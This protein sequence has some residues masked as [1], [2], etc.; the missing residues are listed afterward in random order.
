MSLP[1]LVKHVYNNA[2]DDIIK[3]GKKIQA[4]GNTELV[5]IDELTSS[6]VFR[7]KDDTYNS[8]FKVHIQHFSN[9]QHFKLK[10]TCSFSAGEICKHKAA[11]L[12][13]LQDLIDRNELS[14]LQR[15]YDQRHTTLK[16]KALEIGVIKQSCSIES[17]EEAEAFLQVQKA[18]IL[19]AQDEQ[20]E[21]IVNYKGQDYKVLIVKN[22]ERNFDTS[23]DF[24]DPHNLL[25]VQKVIVLVQIIKQ[26]GAN[27]FDTI[28]NKDREKNLLLGIYG[29]SLNDDIKGKFEF[30][31]KN[32]KPFL[33]LLDPSI[34]RL[35][36]I[37]KPVIAGSSALKPT[38]I[39][40]VSTSSNST[41]ETTTIPSV[42]TIIPLGN[43]ILKPL[44]IVISQTKKFPFIQ[45]IPVTGQ[46]GEDGNI[47]G[48]LEIVDI[49][50]NIEGKG[51]NGSQ[52]EVLQMVRKLL[53]TEVSRYV[54]RNSPFAGFWDSLKNDDNTELPDIDT[55]NIISEYYIPRMYR[56]FNEIGDKA[57]ILLQVLGRPL[58]SK[59]VEQVK[60]FYEDTNLQ[61][62]VSKTKTGYEI[63]LLFDKHKVNAIE[64]EWDS[65][66]IIKQNKNLYLLK[67]SED[68]KLIQKFNT[69]QYKEVSKKD[70]E[71]IAQKDI[72]PLAKSQ[73]LYLAPGVAKTEVAKNPKFEMFL[74][75]QGD[76]L[77]FQPQF[78]YH[79]Q[80]T[81]SH[82]KEQLFMF[83]NGE[84][85]QLKRNIKEEHVFVE[86]FKSL[87]DRFIHLE[88]EESFALKGLDVLKNNW[89][90]LFIDTMKEWEVPVYGFEQLRNYRF[91]TA[92]P[93]TQVYI[94][95][96][97]D[98]FDARVEI[99]FGG[100][101]VSINQIKS[102][103]ADKQAFIQLSDGSLG[104][105]PE[106]WLKKY[107][108]LFKVGETGDKGNL[109]LSK[110]HYSIIDELYDNR[111]ED[112]LQEELEEKFRELE[113]FKNIEPIDP[114]T[115]LE[116]TLRP[117]QVSGFHWLNFLQQVNWGG[118][119]ADDM[120]LGKTLQALTLIQHL[121]NNLEKIRILVVCPTSLLYN[122]ENEI[123]KFTQNLTYL[124][125]HGNNR[126][127][128]TQSFEDTDIIITTYGTLRSDVKVFNNYEYNLIVLDESQAIKNPI[129]KTAKAACLLK[130]QTRLCMSG[131]PL[132]N[133]TFDI[134]AQMNFLNPGMLG[135]IEHFK[136]QFA[137]PIDKL[138]DSETKEHLRRVLFPFILRRTKEQVAKDLPD[139][140]EMVL[141]CEMEDEQRKIYE[142][143][144]NEYRDK[145][146]GIIEEKGI[147]KSQLSILQGLMKLRQI[148]DS[149]AILN[150]EEKLPNASVKLD[151]LA[152]EMEENI[153]N[154]KALIFSQFLG[155][156]SLLKQKLT[157]AGIKYEYF[158]GST[159]A[160]DR[161][162]AIKSFQENDEVRV[163][164][165]SLKAGGVGLNL[166]AADYVYIVDPW[167]NPAV[168]Q[169]AIDR[170]HRIGQT[171][172]IF[173][174]R[175]IC[176]DTVE[177]KILQLQERKKTLAKEIISDEEGF[178]KQLSRADVE[179]LFS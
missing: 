57:P 142:A 91:N 61:C 44:N 6:A 153:S 60:V 126:K 173:A 129:S 67:S 157:E 93:T 160:P 54:Q 62:K 68:V 55:Q 49:N 145:I 38:A 106:E 137:V 1:Y 178:V 19:K 8:Y 53:N 122:W 20:V 170:T 134:Y 139:K 40:Q 115:H 59:Y 175:M 47:V 4:I 112:A 125:H 41:T 52:I 17:W 89:F 3:R 168:E 147:Q 148:C 75:E 45:L 144:R 105:L 50:R 65:P 165:I 83:E 162:K 28:R 108:L 37:P 22:E 143:Y 119:L 90:F 161:E 171:K 111:D 158:D 5:E 116:K 114:P 159:S 96:N 92:K 167:W 71:V 138:G 84:L 149:P 118:I 174:Y 133:N 107:A 79:G 72:L 66:I 14:T 12:F 156:L 169:Q 15:E 48:N 78:S 18:T 113:K 177:D 130:A 43:K 42:D 39:P 58:N 30:Y 33:K 46:A 74:K 87:H 31:E 102:A 135:G 63:G 179:Y 23:C 81:H 176:K 80:L 100:Q 85:L 136:N 51:F 131:T 154:H 98:W 11:S 120:G 140:T 10:C 166:T 77:V 56:I 9:P 64:N 82:D 16:I 163:F 26:H 73:S 164:L 36:A 13:K 172:K 94:N 86:R 109:R 97:T 35:E 7:V 21:A 104:I 121:K 2:S 132:Q 124:I 99:D 27:Y 151:E 152:R 95:S 25:C 155:M 103:L 24:Y 127:T 123:K 32:G 76:F 101:K 128:N 146:L 69:P 70:W 88:T 141:Y 110:F 117:Y 29:Y 150:E 34:K